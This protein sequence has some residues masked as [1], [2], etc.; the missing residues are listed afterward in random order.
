MN[1]CC[2]LD[3]LFDVHTALKYDIND[4]RIPDAIKKTILVIFNK[5]GEKVYNKTENSFYKR[6]MNKNTDYYKAT[7]CYRYYPNGLVY[8]VDFGSK[9]KNDEECPLPSSD[10]F[11]RTTI[12]LKEYKIPA[13]FEK[14][15][16][17]NREKIK[18]EQLKAIDEQKKREAKRKAAEDK[19]IAREA[20]NIEQKNPCLSFLDGMGYSS[21]NIHSNFI[22]YQLSK[23]YKEIKKPI[24]PKI[25]RDNPPLYKIMEKLN[26]INEDINLKTVK[27][28]HYEYQA[29]NDRD[30]LI[31]E[32]GSTNNILGKYSTMKILNTIHYEIDTLIED[33]ICKSY[34]YLFQFIIDGFGCNKHTCVLWKQGYTATSDRSIITRFVLIKD[35]K[36]FE[37]IKAEKPR[38]LYN[39]TIVLDKPK[40]LNEVDVKL[41]DECSYHYR[42]AYRHGIYD[43]KNIIA[44]PFLAM[45]CEAWPIFIKKVKECEYGEEW[46]E[47]VGFIPPKNNK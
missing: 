34:E 2:A 6:I 47:R 21:R 10:N 23:W 30:D 7:Y 32:W 31:Y 16:K 45:I 26:Q 43:G 12:M 18:E 37:T 41:S 33:K 24:V 15:I 46:L 27:D 28:I 11:I 9:N 3:K 5:Y 19:K 40:Y 20:I 38:T 14:K 29:K 44:F 17:I 4:E 36:T 13:Y 39:N 35:K 25:F 22:R 8:Y 1:F 42:K